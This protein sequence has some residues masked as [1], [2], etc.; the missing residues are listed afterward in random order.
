I[1]NLIGV[2]SS[3]SE[4]RV[5]ASDLRQR[6]LQR[7][8]ELLESVPGMIVTQHSGDGKA[9][10]YFVRG[11]NLDH[12]TDF[13]TR[14]DGMPV[15]NP[16]HAHGQG[17]T[18]LNFLV[19]ELVDYIDYRLGMQHASMG[20][21]GSAGGAEFHLV[22]SLDR[23]F[24]SLDGGGFGYARLAGGA[25]QRLGAGT[26][27]L[28]GDVKRYHGPWDIA[29]G[30]RKT[31]ALARYSWGAPTSQFSVLAM[32]YHNS[33]DS[34]DQIPL[35][36]VTDGAIDRFGQIDP[37]L[38]G[39]TSRFSLSGAY[40]RIGAR[41]AQ[42]VQLFAIRSMLDLYSNF[43]YFLQDAAKGDQF[44]Q[45][46]HRTVVGVNATHK[47]P[48]HALGTDHLV[49]IG[50]QNRVD[51]VDGLG[52]YRTVARQRVGTIRQDD[53]NESA[54]G[55]Y[56]EAESRWL[57]WLRTTVALRGDAYT[58]DVASDNSANSGKQSDGI[59]SP[60]GSVIFAPSTKV[61]LYVSGGLGFH[62]N[63]AR[64]TTITIDPSTNEAAKRV[65]PLVR[66]RGAEFG[67][68]AT[69]FTGMRST[70]AVWGL[71]LDSE[72]LFVG[73]GG[74][75]EPSEGSRRSGITF[76][77]FYR[78]IPSLSLD[79]DVS[80]ARAR[81][82]TVAADARFIP[83]ALAYVVAAGVTWNG[84]AREPFAALRLRH[85]GSYPLI[86]DNS[87]RATAT[88]LLNGDLGFQVGVT[89][90]QVS[91]LNLLDSNARGVQYYY[92]SRLVGEPMGGVEDVHFHPVE[93]RQLSV[94][95]RWG[96]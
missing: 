19:P 43:T 67:V 18:D 35:R 78:P 15:N 47:T 6:P 21:F 96:L 25:S 49:T 92:A 85:F 31:S 86:E 24:L 33:W 22:R 53:V 48:L 30:V 13:Q 50:L 1:D 29:E 17:Y 93:P 84:V 20:D 87:V 82:T 81:F 32:G 5:G 69:P 26:L 23:P 2:A 72:L 55:L 62:S 4:G 79:A 77:N 71:T 11:F 65:D 73:D 27:L 59:V 58:F 9:N 91:A 54:T 76:A 90:V 38:G 75:T 80:F 8:G 34:S 36:T 61:E 37:T 74:T 45:R 12:G 95:L 41:T 83:G 44:N 3:A 89:R 10:Q 52:L 46:E 42:S 14:L 94:S 60:K 63:D 39:E 57:P 88:T 70:F 66:S 28:G 51:L 40:N 64:G 68:R 56:L 7:E 16:S